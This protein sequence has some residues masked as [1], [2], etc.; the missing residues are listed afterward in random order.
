MSIVKTKTQCHHTPQAANCTENVHHDDD[1]D[2][3]YDADPDSVARPQI[4][5][6]TN[7]QQ[8]TEFNK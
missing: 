2:I 5:S 7:V 1:D 8:M 6:V 3:Q 4:V